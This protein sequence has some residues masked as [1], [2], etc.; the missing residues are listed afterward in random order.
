MNG[1]R[2]TVVTVFGVINI[3]YGGLGVF[4]AGCGALGLALMHGP[5]GQQNP[6]AQ[7]I[8]KTPA[9]LTWS[10]VSPILM[11]FF[12]LLLIAAGIGLLGLRPWGR[13]ASL[14]WGVY[15]ALKAVAGAV[16]RVLFVLPAMPDM[17]QQ[18]PGQFGAAFQGGMVFGVAAAA[19]IGLVYP[20]CILYFMTRPSFIEAFKGPPQDVPSAASSQ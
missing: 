9:L 5:M 14:V 2:P 13:T 11:F 18:N 20:L 19:M 1:E 7:A 15:G 10:V 17:M 16:I 12:S 3:V 6:G 4:V 8:W